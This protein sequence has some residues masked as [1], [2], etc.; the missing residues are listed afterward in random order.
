ML[1]VGSPFFE[2]CIAASQHGVSRNRRRRALKR[3][4]IVRPSPL[5]L[6]YPYSENRAAGPPFFEGRFVASR[7]HMRFGSAQNGSLTSSDT[8]DL[9]ASATFLPGN[10]PLSRNVRRLRSVMLM[11]LAFNTSSI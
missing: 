7:T 5:Q 9:A 4:A 3:R 1:A 2:R 11:P 8:M 10:T 6:H